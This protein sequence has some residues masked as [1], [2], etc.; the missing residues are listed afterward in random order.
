MHHKKLEI[1]TKI[2]IEVN[3]KLEGALVIDESSLI[4][5]ARA[6]VNSILSTY[7]ESEQLIKVPKFSLLYNGE[8]IEVNFDEED[9]NLSLR[10]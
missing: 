2:T 8:Q 3:K 10:G 1:W 4:T 5:P 9:F 6:K 7:V